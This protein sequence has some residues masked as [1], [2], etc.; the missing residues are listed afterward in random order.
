MY[1]FWHD[2]IKPKYHDRIN[3]FHID[4]D[5]FIVNIYSDDAYKDVAN[6]IEKK[7][8]KSNY[9]VEKL[10]AIDKNKMWLD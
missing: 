2:H 1:Q 9:E 3:L 6:D 7:S 4:T 5:R 8:D 10:L